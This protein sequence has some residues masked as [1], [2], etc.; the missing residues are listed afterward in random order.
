MCISRRDDATVAVRAMQTIRDRIIDESTAFD[1]RRDFACFWL[2]SNWK[3][4]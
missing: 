2:L 1:C 4:K 3:I